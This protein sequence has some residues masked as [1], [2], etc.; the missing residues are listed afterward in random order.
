MLSFMRESFEIVLV[1][2]YKEGS[3]DETP[4]VVQEIASRLP[5]VRALALPKK[6][7]MGWDMRMGLNEA[8][9]K[10]IGVIDGDGQFPYESIFACLFKIEF[11]N[12]D[13]VKTYRVKRG[14]GLYRLLISRVYNRVFNLLFGFGEVDINSKPKILRRDKYR[15]LDLR[16]DDWFLDTELMIRAHEMGFSIGEI[17]IHFLANSERDSFVTL[18][19]ISEFALNLLRFRFGGKKRP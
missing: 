10:Y 4:Q 18:Q 17:P 9:G 12:L 5:H 8:R 13:M 14:D 16:S 15:L 11:Q 1:G 19:S 7:M 3:Q 2:N 6:G